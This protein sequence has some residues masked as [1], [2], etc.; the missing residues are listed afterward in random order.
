MST[1]FDVDIEEIEKTETSDL[2]YSHLILKFKGKSVDHVLLNTLR[3]IVI[4]NIPTYAFPSE[5]ILIEQNTSVFNNDQMK[6]R[7]TQLPILKTK[8][9]L[10]FL[11]EEFWLNVDFNDSERPKHEK[12]RDIEI[13]ISAVNTENQTINVTTNDIQYYIDGELTEQPYNKKYPIVLIK[14][15]PQEIFRC[16]MK[17]ILGIGERNVIWVAAGNAY[18]NLNEND[19]TFYIESHGI[20]DE[21]EILW[22]ACKYMKLKLDDMKKKLYDKYIVNQYKD[23]ELKNVE[24]IL[25]HETYTTCGIITSVLQERDDIEFA[26]T[27]K[28][29]ELVKQITILVTYKKEMKKPIE[30]IFEAIDEVSR[31]MELLENKIYLLG[32]KYIQKSNDDKSFNDDSKKKV[33]KTSKKQK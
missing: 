30:P 2:D 16:R 15:R 8:L 22:K 6:I 3:R 13:Y 12:E 25:D 1:K 5:H 26:G 9:D 17:A 10:A 19:S 7:L 23:E 4:N 11:P 20:F 29:N 27:S 18:Y 32:K 14:L 31:R 28:Y 21:Y 24:I 33:K